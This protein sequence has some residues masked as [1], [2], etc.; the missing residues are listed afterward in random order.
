MN[1][2]VIEQKFPINHTVAVLMEVISELL[3]LHTKDWYDGGYLILGFSL[4]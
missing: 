2:F 4:Q 1:N 3:E